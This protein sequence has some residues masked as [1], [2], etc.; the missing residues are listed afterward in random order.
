MG[1][2]TDFFAA[3]TAELDGVSIEWGPVPPAA[4]S[5]RPSASPPKSGGVFG[6]L[7]RRPAV[8]EPAPEPAAE[9][10]VAAE[11]A[12]LPNVQSKG[13][14]DTQVSALDTIIT[15][16]SYDELLDAEATG[17]IVRDAGDE[18]PWIFAIRTE[19]RDALAALPQSEVDRVGRAWAADE[20]IG[21]TGDA[22]VT[23]IVELTDE[24]RAL[25]ITARSTGR[26]LYLWASL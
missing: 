18:G 23:A 5:G 26:D 12:V 21:A 15:G 16:T 22:D 11:E 9:P 7:R 25:A 4:G 17:Q 1:V 13:I 3:T 14:L 10:A 8:P 20:E 19:L 24:L 2:L 6:F